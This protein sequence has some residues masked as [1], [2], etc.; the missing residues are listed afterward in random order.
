[1][2]FTHVVYVDEAGDEG[3]GKL[4]LP[5]R[6]GQSQWLLLGSM[7]ARGNKDAQL[8]KWRNAILDR[9]PNSRRSDLHFI[10][11]K[12]EQKVVVC[13]EIA[14][15]PLFSCVVFSNKKTIPGSSWAELFKRPGYLY[16]Y[17]TRWLLERVTAFCAA[18]SESSRQL[19]CK[20]KVVFS[21][22]GGTDYRSMAEYLCLMRDGREVVRPARQINWNVFDPSD[23]AVEN[24]SVRVGLQF[25][26]A[27]TSAFFSAV[28]PNVYGNYETQ[29][30]EI[31]RQS[32]VRVSG[33]AL[34]AGVTPVPS[35]PGC[36]CNEHQTTFFRSFM[37]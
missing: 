5:D 21:R 23:I 16:N 2:T 14:R 15:L 27:F 18:D 3:F 35:L 26:D 6:G 30:A 31:L 28:E 32:V 33:N 7:I 24:H 20:V 25:S 11:L 37:R 13:Q 9:F 17:M 36:Q 1:M 34:N 8:P 4:R 29:Y 10:N 22:R 19:P 12:H